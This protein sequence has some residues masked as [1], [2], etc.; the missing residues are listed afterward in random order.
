MKTRVRFLAYLPASFFLAFLIWL[1]LEKPLPCDNIAF[2][3]AIAI[4]ASTFL[5][6]LLLL[7]LNAKVFESDRA[8]CAELDK[9]WHFIVALFQGFEVA[10]FLFVLSSSWLEDK[11]DWPKCRAAS[12]VAFLVTLIV[13]SCIKNSNES[14][15]V[16]SRQ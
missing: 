2:T 10:A 4:S 12:M 7:I 13:T 11:Y 16:D 6:V 8:A 1:W 5:D 14:L 3:V 9:F 15:K